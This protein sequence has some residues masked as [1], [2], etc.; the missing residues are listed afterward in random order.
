MA[1]DARHPEA[2]TIQRLLDWT[3]SHFAK[4]GIDSARLDAELLLASAL[5]VDRVYLYTH[6]DKPLDPEERGPFREY[7]RRRGAREP[8]S[9]ILGRR[10]FYGR[11]FRVT[12]DVLTPRPE[13]EHLVD[14]VLEWSKG[15]PVSR[16]LDLC[17]GS[18]AIAVSIAAEMPETQVVA[19]DISEP[20]LAV[21]R[22]NVEALGVG[23]KVD[24]RLGSL[25]EPVAGE[26][27]AIVVCNP[28]YVAAG[29][30]DALPPEVREHEPDV[31]LF[32]GPDGL[33]VIRPLCSQALAHLR[34]G[35]LLA[36]EIGWRQG[37][38]VQKLLAEAGFQTIEL[39]PDLQG[40]PRVVLASNHAE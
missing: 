30:R 23:A 21:A 17:T 25:F 1:E 20:A 22:S 38:T 26:R 24:L 4:H 10:E 6:F 34:P 37:E 32:G 19:T 7:V 31:A 36:L 27:F 2:W 8:V 16:V 29:E 28:P 35:G 14:A 15:Q 40:H 39:R 5:G 18:G 12:A 13:T 11:A 3:Q 9:Q 33:E